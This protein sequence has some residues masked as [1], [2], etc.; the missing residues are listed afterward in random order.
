MIINHFTVNAPNSLKMTIIYILFIWC[1]TISAYG[2]VMNRA[3]AIFS[4]CFELKQIE[5]AVY[6]HEI[7]ALLYYTYFYERQLSL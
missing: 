6:G 3:T 7:D 1:L 2:H 5:I 4:A